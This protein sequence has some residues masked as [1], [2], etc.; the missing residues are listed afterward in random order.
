M[1]SNKLIFL[2]SVLIQMFILTSLVT[3]SPLLTMSVVEGGELPWG[4][5][6]TELLFVLFPLNF[7]LVRRQ[8]KVHPIPQKFYNTTVVLAM[9][10][11]LLWLPVSYW[12]SG[13]WHSTFLGEDTEQQISES[14]T[15]AT[16]IL[17]FV[18]YIGRG[19]LGMFFKK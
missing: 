6:M 3:A 13:N 17:P 14:Y 16:P 5:V 18:G 19:I 9:V 2:F 4:N 11:G 7:L 12:L 15:Y 8:R 10:M 1:K